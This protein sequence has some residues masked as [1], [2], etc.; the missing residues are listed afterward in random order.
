MAKRSSVLEFAVLGLLHDN[1]C[2]DTNFAKRLNAVLGSFRAIS[3]GSLYPCLQ[4]TTG[5]GSHPRG[6]AR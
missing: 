3:Y 2:T 6:W 4:A 5:R 1:P